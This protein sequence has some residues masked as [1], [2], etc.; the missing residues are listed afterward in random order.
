MPNPFETSFIPQQPLLK[1]EGA[2]QRR[3]PI[4]VALIVAVIIFCVTALIGGGLYYW[5][6][7]VIK[8]V[9]AKGFELQE[10]EKYFRVEDID[11]YKH[12]QV[13]LDTAKRLVDE[14]VIFSVVFDLIEERAAQNIALTSLNYKQEAEGTLVLLAGQSPS[15]AALYFQIEAWRKMTPVVKKVELAS[16]TLQETT[17]LVEFSAKVLVD[18]AYLHSA[19]VLQ[20]QAKEQFNAPAASFVPPALQEMATNTPRL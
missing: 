10:A 15:Y 14:H 4:N 3:E 5:K 1:V 19:S 8:Q 17:G 18:S 11:M 7:Q 9:E 12:L 6:L 13:S 16:F 2:S 20:A